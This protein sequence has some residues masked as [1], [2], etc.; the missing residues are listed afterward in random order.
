[1]RSLR[2]RGNND[3]V[4]SGSGDGADARAERLKGRDHNSQRRDKEKCNICIQNECVF[5]FQGK[6]I[7][8]S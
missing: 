6:T 7:E 1:M 4:V 8:L 5:G 3:A 2:R